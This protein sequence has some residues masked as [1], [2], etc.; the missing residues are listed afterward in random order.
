MS[1]NFFFSQDE[2]GPIRVLQRHE[3]LASVG[4]GSPEVLRNKLVR[5]PRLRGQRGRRKPQC[6]PATIG[7]IL[8]NYFVKLFGIYVVK[9]VSSQGT[10]AT[11]QFG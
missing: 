6:R 4:A 8:K 3:H 5:R 2:P 10:L 9:L 1:N 7:K 11:I